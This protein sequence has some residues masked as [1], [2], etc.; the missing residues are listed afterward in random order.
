MASAISDGKFKLNR[1]Y[2]AIL[3]TLIYTSHITDKNVFS[4]FMTQLIFS[5]IGQETR[6]ISLSCVFVT[7]NF[8]KFKKSVEEVLY[9]PVQS[10]RFHP[11][12]HPG[13]K[14]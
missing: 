8:K 4:V 7:S 12:F 14:R 2:R 6:S 9:R 10:Y 5:S 13:T 11:C 3:N 1:I